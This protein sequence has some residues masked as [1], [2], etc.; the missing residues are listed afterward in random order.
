MYSVA[1]SARA[2]IRAHKQP[3][4]RPSPS[5]P[6]FQ[7]STSRH[8]RPPHGDPWACSKGRRRFPCPPSLAACGIVSPPPNRRSRTPPGIQGGIPIADGWTDGRTGGGMGGSMGNPLC[9]MCGLTLPGAACCS[10]S[11][12]WPLSGTAW[13]GT[14]RDG[15]DYYSYGGSFFV[16]YMLCDWFTRVGGGGVPSL[17]TLQGLAFLSR[18]DAASPAGWL[19]LSLSLSLS[20]VLAIAALSY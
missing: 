7:S 5:P 11:C 17:G 19:S 9:V 14:P 1:S 13:T 18:V 12:R 8:R 16:R 3:R 20:L 6:K 2:W 10:S 15:D 4:N